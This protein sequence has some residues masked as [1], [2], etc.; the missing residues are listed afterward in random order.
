MLST[1]TMFIF[2]ELDDDGLEITVC[3]PDSSTYE[4]YP[5]G[6]SAIVDT[7]SALERRP[8]EAVWADLLAEHAP[9]PTPNGTP[10]ATVP[11]SPTQP[12]A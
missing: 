8:K 3:V 9:A 10:P 11:E 7:L 6:V 4:D 2:S 12:L 1:G 5:R